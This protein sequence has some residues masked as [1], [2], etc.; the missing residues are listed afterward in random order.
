MLCVFQTDC[1][2]GR[3]AVEEAER[4]TGKGKWTRGPAG[5]HGPRVIS[6]HRGPRGWTARASAGEGSS[7]SLSWA[8]KK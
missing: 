6:H 8:F 3:K 4:P 1:R 2:A 5:A 7:P